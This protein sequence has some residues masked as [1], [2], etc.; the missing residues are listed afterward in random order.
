MFKIDLLMSQFRYEIESYKRILNFF[1]EE[2]IKF[3]KRLSEFII[4][5][6]TEDNTFMEQVE[7][8]HNYLL[9][10]DEFI[11]F[12][13]AELTDQEKLISQLPNNELA[14]EILHTQN[15]I[16]KELQFVEDDFHKLTFEL[17][18]YLSSF[19]SAG[20]GSTNYHFM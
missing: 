12:L 4:E 5:S 9:K 6:G 14:K 15:K 20:M 7:Y 13:Q 10:E 1:T 2:N 19:L 18:N 16:R 17:N 3:K 11:G 8:F